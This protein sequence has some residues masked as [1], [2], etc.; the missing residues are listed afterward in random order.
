MENPMSTEKIIRNTPQGRVIEAE[1]DYANF[2]VALARVVDPLTG[3]RI[4]LSQE[5]LNS[6]TELVRNQVRHDEAVAKAAQVVAGMPEALRNL[7]AD[8]P[9]H[10]GVAPYLNELGS[11]RQII[12]RTGERMAQLDLRVGTEADHVV[13][14]RAPSV[15][16]LRNGEIQKT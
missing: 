10:A 6:L 5:G 15:P 11:H 3:V 12:E 16:N 9:D 13:E 2:Q 14:G 4:P 8:D 7:A 1:V